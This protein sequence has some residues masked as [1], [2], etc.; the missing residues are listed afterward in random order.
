MSYKMPVDKTVEKG[1]LAI[2][3]VYI[4]SFIAILFF[5][6][7]HFFKPPEF[8]ACEKGKLDPRCVCPADEQYIGKRNIIFVDTTDKIPDGKIED[9]YRLIRETAFVEQDFWKWITSGKKVEKTSIYL[10]SNQKP[11]DM[12]P[13]ASYCSF[14]PDTTWLFTELSATQE[15]KIKEVAVADVKKAVN[16]I[17]AHNDT[18]RSHIV[19]ALAT[20]TSNATY[21]KAGSKLIALS[22]LYENSATCGYFEGG[23]IPLFSNITP[24]CKKWVDILGKNLARQSKNT[25]DKERSNVA[26]CQILS[27]NQQS[28]IITFWRELFQSQGLGVI[29]TCD[30]HEIADRYR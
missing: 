2:K 12:V 26:V 16:G 28:G 8:T 10:L 1:G 24:E 7:S 20:V 30:P 13:I 15:K 25:I 4:A 11:V 19:Q 14:P 18:G 5:A 21:W 6:A 3:S 23:I 9:L 22:D 17:L 29:F 27:K